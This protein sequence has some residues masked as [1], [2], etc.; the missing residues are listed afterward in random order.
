MEDTSSPSHVVTASRS[1]LPPTLMAFVILRRVSSGVFLSSSN[2]RVL[3]LLIANTSFSTRRPPPDQPY[4]DGVW[5]P[6]LHDLNGRWYIYF[7]ANHPA[8]GNPSHRMW[9]LGGGPSNQ[10]PLDPSQWQFLG[11]I[12][13]MP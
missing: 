12:K 9:V 8:R 5:A 2:P 7:A 3:E 1:G 4:S 6:E 13:G 10:D 11:G